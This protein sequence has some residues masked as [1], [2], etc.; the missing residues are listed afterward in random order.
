M[1]KDVFI[2]AVSKAFDEVAHSPYEFKEEVINSLVKEFFEKKSH[3]YYKC[4]DQD[5][6]KKILQPDS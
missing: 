3:T 5:F 2:K 4:S 1:E 6:T